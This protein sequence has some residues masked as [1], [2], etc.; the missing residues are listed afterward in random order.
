MAFQPKPRIAAEL[1]RGVAVLGQSHLDWVTA[2]EEYGK[3]G[4]FLD[5]MDELEQR[6]VVEVPVTTTVWTEDPAGC[7]PA[8]WRPG[9][10]ADAADAGGRAVRGRGG[11]GPAG[12]GVAGPE[13]PRG[14]DAARWSSSSRRCGSGRCATQKP[15]RRSGC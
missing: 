1:V 15:G 11:R 12:R 6:Y 13:G 9:P 10:S 2:D 5:A 14:G 8:Y 3:A 4:H 7:V